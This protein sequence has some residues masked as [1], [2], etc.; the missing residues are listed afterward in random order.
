MQNN[1]N[2]ARV[3]HHEQKIALQWEPWQ[4]PVK[5]PLPSLTPA[6]PINPDAMRSLLGI[7]ERATKGNEKSEAQDT[8]QRTSKGTKHKR[9]SESVSQAEESEELGEDAD[10]DQ[11]GADDSDESGTE[12]IS[13]QRP[14]VVESPI[15]GWNHG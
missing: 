12:K 8:A 6:K 9:E 5:V 7:K 11:E 14:E 13:S 4:S 3:V 2:T 15:S 10:Q 1:E